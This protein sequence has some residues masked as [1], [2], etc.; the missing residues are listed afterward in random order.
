MNE[1]SQDR[2]EDPARIREL[3]LQNLFLVFNE[4]DPERRLQVIARN[5]TEDVL[6]TDPGGTTEG[7]EAMNEKAQKLLDGIPGFVFNAAGPVYVS[8]GLG[9]LAF[10]HG[11]P[12]QPPGVSGFDVALVRDGRIAELHTLVNAQG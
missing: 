4:R 12:E 6:W 1:T 5:Y 7:H 11:L 3:L 2:V 9:L 8:R 10:I